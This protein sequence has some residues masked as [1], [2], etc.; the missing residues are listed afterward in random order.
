[1]YLSCVT[2]TPL[3]GR[4]TRFPEVDGGEQSK[5][6]HA[7]VHTGAFLRETSNERL[8]QLTFNGDSQRV[9][10]SRPAAL[11]D[12]ASRRNRRDDWLRSQ[13]ESVHAIRPE[14]KIPRKRMF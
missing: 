8:S 13:R 14:L 11:P 7:K 1:M 2:S 12:R 5:H 6:V 3:T 9:P 4:P 10:P